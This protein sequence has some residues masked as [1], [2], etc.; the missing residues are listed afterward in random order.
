MMLVLAEITARVFLTRRDFNGLATIEFATKIRVY[1][2]SIKYRGN[3]KGNRELICL[4]KAANDYPRKNISPFYQK[5]EQGFKKFLKTANNIPVTI[6]YLPSSEKRDLH[7]QFFSDLSRK[8]S[9]EFIDMSNTLR[10]SGEFET[11]TLKPENGHLSRFGNRIIAN[12]LSGYILDKYSNDEKIFS[13][14]KKIIK[15]Q[16]ASLKP[17]KSSI[18][19]ID[20]RMVYRVYTNKNGF[21]TKNEI[22]SDGY[23]V[24]VYGDSFTFGPYLA[25]HDTY[26]EITNKNLFKLG[27]KNIQILNAGI[28]GSTIF[29][30]IETLKKTVGLK[31]NLIIL[32]VLD[33]D[34]YEVSYAKMRHTQPV[35]ISDSNLLKP[36]V[37][38]IKILENCDI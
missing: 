8:Y 3:N 13:R 35:M 31:P 20:P 32:Q 34:I 37:E 11:W 28:A 16:I 21:R 27:E 7:K 33:N 22:K 1:L 36:S 4:A 29:H 15:S 26:T 12:Q 19:N 2:N 30:Q 38:E 9:L 25:N 24:T 6:L 17:S 14:N 23:I 10:T 18:W 5:Y